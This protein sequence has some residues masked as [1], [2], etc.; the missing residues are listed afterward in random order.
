MS[1]MEGQ[2]YLVRADYWNDW[3]SKA[4]QDRS[5]HHSGQPTPHAP[6]SKPLGSYLVEAGLLTEDQ[7][8]VALN[9]QKVT[10]MR[11]GEILVARGWLK[12]QTIEW[13]IQKVVIP[14]N[15][16][17]QPFDRPTPPSRQPHPTRQRQHGESSNRQSSNGQFSNGQSSNRPNNQPADSGQA[18]GQSQQPFSQLQRIALRNGD[19]VTVRPLSVPIPTDLSPA[20]TS[21]PQTLATDRPEPPDEPAMD[22]FD[23]PPSDSSGRRAVPI[24]KPLPPVKTVDGEVNWVG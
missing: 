8:K 5:Q 20:S 21:S 12:E 23:N 3:W 1:C 18:N 16:V 4:M 15:R 17:Q 22:L 14:E 10:G 2:P 19:V 7:V 11:F 6:R 9:D 24:S 13:V